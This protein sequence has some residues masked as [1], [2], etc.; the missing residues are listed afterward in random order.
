MPQSDSNHPQ[1]EVFRH[2]PTTR[3]SQKMIASKAGVHPS[4]VSLALRN[5]PEVAEETRQR[6]REI[7][8]EMHYVEDPFLSALAR[9]RESSKR[10]LHPYP[11]A[12]VSERI[13]HFELSIHHQLFRKAAIE[14]AQQFGF[15]LDEFSLEAGAYEPNRLREVI[16]H[17]AIEG[18]LL[19]SFLAGRS[20]LNLDWDHLSCVRIGHQPEYPVFHSVAVNHQQV[21]RL[22]V[23]ETIELG[24]QRP[25]FLI[26]ADW[27][28][29]V[30]D[31]WQMGFLWAQQALKPEERLPV[32]GFTLENEQAFKRAVLRWY[33]THKPDVIIGPED[34]F[35]KFLE[36][37]GLECPGEIAFVDCFQAQPNPRC[38]GVV[39]PCVRVGF[40]AV[41]ILIGML[42]QHKKGPAKEPTYTMI[43]GYWNN[44][45]SCPPRI[46]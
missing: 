28:R 27:S 1:K 33:Q 9:Y 16:N 22:A 39:H 18:I 20:T 31:E 40:Q 46:Q 45:P 36:I 41:D 44:G 30:D 32:F 11:I 37:S 12:L 8:S 10:T 38:A 7:A 34:M 6:I 29:L 43:N 19:S 23:S 24:Y 3:V 14:R 21:I 17:R 2:K 13:P 15:R 42:N 26:G 25:G 4:T 5:S 35:L